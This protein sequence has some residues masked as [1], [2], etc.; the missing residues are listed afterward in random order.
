MM[1]TYKF[2]S[3]TMRYIKVIANI[4][5]PSLMG[6]SYEKIMRVINLS[7][8]NDRQDLRAEP[9]YFV[10]FPSNHW[11][12]LEANIYSS[13]TI[14]LTDENNIP[15]VFTNSS[16]S[17]EGVFVVESDSIQSKQNHIDVY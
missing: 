17:V 8:R 1:Y 4:L 2:S 13:V 7:D 10:S 6:Q 5:A 16:E 3:L 11:V 15:L 14:T 9:G 12:K